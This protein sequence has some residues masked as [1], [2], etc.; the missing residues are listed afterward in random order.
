MRLFAI[1]SK[2]LHERWEDGDPAG[3]GIDQVL[4]KIKKH[5]VIRSSLFS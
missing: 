3:N 5:S 1:S 4:I 2:R